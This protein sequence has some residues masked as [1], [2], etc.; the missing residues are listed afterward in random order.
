MI[1]ALLVA[2]ALMFA[3]LWRLIRRT[4]PDEKERDEQVC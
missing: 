4:S 2:V 3:V 1:Y